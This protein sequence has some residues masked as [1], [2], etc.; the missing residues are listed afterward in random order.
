MSEVDFVCGNEDLNK[1]LVAFQ[2]DR[3]NFF[4]LRSIEDVCV[5]LRTVEKF[6]DV[7]IDLRTHDDPR[8]IIL[9]VS[10][11]AAEEVVEKFKKAVR[12][13]E[14]PEP[15]LHKTCEIKNGNIEEASKL[16]LMQLKRRL[17]RI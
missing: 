6:Y 15:I 8:K 2:I 3:P 9:R 14:T 1:I 4:G 10:G 16:L 13:V 17:K 11:E 12:G 7:N 5:S